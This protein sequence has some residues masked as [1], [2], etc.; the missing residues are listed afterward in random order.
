VNPNAEQDQ[1]KIVLA[2]NRDELYDRKTLPAHRWVDNPNCLGGIDM[3]VGRKGGTWL[4]M[5]EKRCQ[6][7]GHPQYCL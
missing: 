4:A 6:N 2:C 3:K 5:N 1:Y 7:R